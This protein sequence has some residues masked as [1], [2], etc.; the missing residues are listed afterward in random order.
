[1]MALEDE[2]ATT[3]WSKQ[4]IVECVVGSFLGLSFLASYWIASI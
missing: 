1:M 4:H 3:A 2:Y